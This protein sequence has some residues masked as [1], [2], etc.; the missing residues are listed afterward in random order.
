MAIRVV[1]I[2]GDKE[3]DVIEE[4]KGWLFSSGTLKI[5]NGP[6]GN[7]QTRVLI[8]IREDY[9]LSAEYVAPATKALPKP[10]ALE[11]PPTEVETGLSDSQKG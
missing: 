3:P 2:L 10:K 6:P 9:V 11:T 8:E 4:A 7:T 5:L 1:Y